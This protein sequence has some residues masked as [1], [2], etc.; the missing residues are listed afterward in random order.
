MV[1]IV[2]IAAL[3]ILQ[4]VF[5]VP[6]F[7]SGGGPYWPRA[8]SYS[9]FHG[10]WWHLAVNCLAVWTIYKRPCKPC[11]DLLF[12]FMIAVLVYPL[13]FRPVIGFSNILYAE[14][15][16][17]TPPVK[18]RWWRQPSVIIFISVT[19]AMAALPRFAAATHIA[20]FLLGMAA[21]S[22]KR[23]THDLAKDAGRYR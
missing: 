2:I 17:H 21:A 7:L 3:V 22:I 14:L 11:G 12:P 13:S 9:F 16:I 20:A 23:L 5:G 4:W 1:R 8:L 18:S 15:G 19:L 10:N 6:E